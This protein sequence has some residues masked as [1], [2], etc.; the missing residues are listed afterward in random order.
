MV[1]LVAHYRHAQ[2][3]LLDYFNSSMVRLVGSW[4]DGYF[5][6]KKFQFQY[7]TIG[8]KEDLQKEAEL[9]DFNS[10]MVRLVDMWGS[11]WSTKT[12]ISIPVWYDW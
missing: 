12:D 4:E 2:G 5:E 10:S 11:W 7:G 9:R 1:R 8:R 6:T 3:L